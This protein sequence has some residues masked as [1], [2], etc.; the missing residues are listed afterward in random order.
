MLFV[1]DMMCV[2]RRVCSFRENKVIITFGRENGTSRCNSCS[3]KSFCRK[4][5]VIMFKRNIGTARYGVSV[6]ESRCFLSRK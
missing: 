1:Q 2:V 3:L 5:R 4:K 6:A